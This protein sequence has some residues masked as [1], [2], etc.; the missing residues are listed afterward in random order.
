MESGQ[1]QDSTGRLPSWWN[2]KPPEQRGDD[3]YLRAF[4]E[5]SSCRAFGMAIGPIPWHYVIQ[6]AQHHGL[7]D[8]MTLV[9]EVVMRTMDEAYMKSLNDKPRTPKSRKEA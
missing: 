1:Y 6:Y 4:W 3:F 8:R 2:D 5:L 7:D 9:F